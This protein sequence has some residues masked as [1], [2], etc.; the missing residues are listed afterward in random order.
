M[1]PHISRSIDYLTGV[2]PNRSNVYYI[3][4]KYLQSFLFRLPLRVDLCHVHHYSRTLTLAS[5]LTRARGTLVLN[6]RNLYTEKAIKE[7]ALVAC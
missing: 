1:I 3:S 4:D 5:V 2:E 6:A 7:G